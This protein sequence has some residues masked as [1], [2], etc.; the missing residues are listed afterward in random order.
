MATVS[1]GTSQY[2]RKLSDIILFSDILL[3]TQKQCYVGLSTLNK[4]VE[5]Q[6]ATT[7]VTIQK[8]SFDIYKKRLM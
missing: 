8:T 6:R 1:S 5:T 4:F 3:P 7:L 2:Y